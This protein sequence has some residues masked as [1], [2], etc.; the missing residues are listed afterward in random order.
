[1]DREFEKYLFHAN[2]SDKPS[3]IWKRQGYSTFQHER[4]S[5][6]TASR[7]GEDNIMWGSDYPH[8]DS[9]WP[10]S[11][12]VIRENLGKLEESTLRKIIRDNA[13]KLYRFQLN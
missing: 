11:Q 5:M 12:K 3:E 8:Q 1:M 2:L 13:A 10:S 9:V 7:V 4:L 6:E